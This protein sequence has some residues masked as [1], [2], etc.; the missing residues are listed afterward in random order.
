MLIYSRGGS[1]YGPIRPLPPPPSPF[2]QL[3]HANSAFW[4]GGGAYQ[5]IFPQFRHSAPPPLFLQ[6]LG[7]AL[8]YRVFWSITVIWN[9]LPLFSS[10]TKCDWISWCHFGIK[11][12]SYVKLLQILA[13]RTTFCTNYFWNNQS[14]VSIFYFPLHHYCSLFVC[15]VLFCF[16][17]FFYSSCIIVGIYSDTLG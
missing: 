8:I 16:V 13:V 1:R 3:N 17:L 10:V 14:I 6:I 11:C 12:T 15:F 9:I 5:P 2:W 4:G 7:P